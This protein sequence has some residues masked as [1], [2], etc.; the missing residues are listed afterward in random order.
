[1]NLLGAIN[2]KT[3]KYTHPF[4]ASKQDEYMCI[5]C[6]NDVLIKQGTLKSHH[7]A[8]KSS[9]C[10]CYT[11]NESDEHKNAKLILKYILENKIPLTICCKCNKCNK[12]D[13]YEIEEISDNSSIILE[14]R[15]EYNNG[16]KYADLAYI[17]DNEILCIFEIYNSHKTDTEDRPEPWFELDAKQLIQTVNNSDLQQIKL[18]CI[19]DKLCDDCICQEIKIKNQREK[20]KI[21]FNQRGAGCGKTYESIQL[22]LDDRFNDKDTF[23][24]LT[25]MHS[26]KEVIFNELKEQEEK[27]KLNILEILENNNSYGKQ[28]K[29][30]YL[31]KETNKKIV[32]IIGT[33]DSF[34]NAIV[35]KTKIIKHNDYFKGIVKTIINGFLS[36]K[37]SKIN[38]A[39]KTPSLNKKCLIIIDEAQDLC[40]EY[41]KAFN[42]IIN[43]T[44]I[45]VYV[46]GDKLQSILGEDNIHTY[47]DS[48]NLDTE[49]IKSTG[50]NKVMR[51]HNNH[52]INF[53]NNVIPFEKHGLPPITEICDGCCKYKHENDITPYTIFEVPKIYTN[54]YDYNK[55][56]ITIEKIISYLNNEIDKYNY[57]PNN[58]MF[59]F[60]ILSKNTFAL[61]LELELQNFWINKYKDINYQEKVLKYNDYWKDKINDNEFY[62][63]VYL[64]KSDEGKSINL[65]ESVNS[66]R[67]LSIHSSKGNGC[68]VVFVFGINEE[69]LTMF[70]KE[71]YNLVYDSLLHVAITRQKKSIYIGIEKNDDDIYNRFK[72]LGIKEDEEIQPRIECIK[73]FNQLSK[74]K[75]SI[76]SN[77]DIFSK[78]NDTII[79]PNN[80]KQLIPDNKNNKPVIDWGHHTVRHA[81]MIYNLMLNIINNEVIE[82]QEYKNQFITILRKISTKSINCY[83]YIIYNK[84]LREI[85]NNNKHKKINNEIPL[86]SFDTKENT[87]YY[88]YTN[89]LKNII[90][91]IQN[92]IKKY[93][94][95]DDLPPLCPL[96]CVVLLF[97][98]KLTDDGYYSDISIMDIYSIMYC[99]DSCCKEINEEH[100]EKNECICNNCFNEVNLNY[101]SDNEIINSIKNHYN[102][103]EHI[104]TI[105]IN[106]NKYITEKLQI[107]NITY[108]IFHKLFIKNKNF[109]IMNVFTIIGY[110]TDAVIYFI[111]KPQFNKLNFNDIICES[112]LN[113]FMI[114]NCSS[115]ENN[116]NRYNNKKI[117]TCILTLD[118]V[119]PIIYELNIDKNNMLIKEIIKN[120]LFVTYSQ[121]HEIIHNFYIFCSKNRPTNKTSVQ[122]TI[123]EL[124]KYEKLPEYIKNYF[125]GINQELK[126]ITDTKDIHDFINNNLI[127]KE[128]FLS[129][130]NKQLEENIDN[131]LKIYR[132]DLSYDY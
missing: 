97:M 58:F 44:N 129:N 33:I 46:I 26:A 126:K 93:I 62:K 14:Y 127:N 22:L 79:E 2:K 28:Y 68:E 19:R 17:E 8:H 96:E 86:L 75:N 72:K 32:I 60:P 101:N 42:T 122:Y 45:D 66:T 83:S 50:I 106:Y 48:H 121:H 65:K 16:T 69:T 36:T 116:Y 91:H 9:T 6:G 54:D 76:S 34:N 7:F 59:I 64:H 1:M 125:L 71:K 25:K 80:Y 112:I 118:S 41:I 51:F 37:N 132:D 47:I 77:D 24:Y 115:D 95:R 94:N 57:L 104:N 105:Y 114:L 21:Y 92:K 61:T 40:K 113:N 110:S 82:N 67:I 78:L 102:N 123:D 70:S 128:L 84:K 120:Y 29:I 81:V 89:N 35:D 56:D 20:G 55:I 88:K 38:Y 98:I 13:N 119:E 18:R 5:E 49:I 3:N 53:V 107:E 99:Y 85:C 111:I 4:N 15:F 108:N 100:I 23:I 10:K 39:G 87:K 124:D 131:F 12:I 27:G 90:K 103:V 73:C 30:S 11:S 74:I 43:L 117:Y 63:Y 109:M 52:F 31:N 130:L